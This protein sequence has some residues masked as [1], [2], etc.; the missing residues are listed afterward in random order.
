MQYLL[1]I[2]GTSKCDHLFGFCLLL[3]AF[4]ITV[5]VLGVSHLP[6]LLSSCFMYVNGEGRT[7]VEQH[8]STKSAFFCV[9][10]VG[11]SLTR[12]THDP[13]TVLHYGTAV[14]KTMAFGTDYS[15]I[16]AVQQY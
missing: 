2:M 5:R 12:M 6:R 8:E 11:R 10:V 1:G 9:G 14:D 13:C 3:V 16:V 4:T 15:T 7:S